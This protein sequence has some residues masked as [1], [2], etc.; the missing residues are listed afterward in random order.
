MQATLAAMKE[1]GFLSADGETCTI[2]NQA[3]L[4][5]GVKPTLS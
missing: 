5:T 2:N 1:L 4:Y 3:L